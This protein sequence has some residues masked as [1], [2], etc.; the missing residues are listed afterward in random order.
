MTFSFKIDAKNRKVELRIANLGKATSKGI[1]QA[2][3]S[4]GK[5][6]KGTAQQSIIDPPKTG[7]IYRVRGKRHQASAAGEAPANLTGALKDSIDFKVG[8]SNSMRFEAGDGKVNYAGFLEDGTSKMAARPFM[9]PA[10]KANER[11][12]IAHFEREIL[13]TIKK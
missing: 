4:I 2:F 11:N 6:L 8:S 13:K 7:R 3:Y 1:N 12:A 10:I 9:I 5:D